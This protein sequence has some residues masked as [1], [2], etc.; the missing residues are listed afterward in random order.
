MSKPIRL[1]PEFIEECKKEFVETLG[2]MKISDGKISFSKILQTVNRK[3][4]VYFSEEAWFKMQALIKEFDKEVAWHGVAHRGED[5][6]KDEYFI[7][8]IVVYPQEVTGTTVEM[9][10]DKYAEWLCDN[11]EDERFNN[12]RM[13][14]HSHVNMGVSP[15]GVDLTHQEEILAQ[16]SDDMFYIFVIWNKNNANHMKI[17]DMK[18]NILFENGDIEYAVLSDGYGIAEFVKDAK[19]MVKEK[20][21]QAIGYQAPGYRY[22]NDGAGGY[23]YQ[24]SVTTKPA[25]GSA[26]AGSGVK[27][28]EKKTEDK[29]T[30]NKGKRRKGKRKKNKYTNPQ[31]S[32]VGD[33]D[34][35]NYPWD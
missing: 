20:S 22:Y 29:G 5:E 17:Y 18:K 32:L 13:Q 34:D 24:S 7:T 8:D 15:S 33:Y 11:F 19:S 35:D 21:Y 26:T 31:I 4:T 28:A 3:A 1:T 14:G 23:G 25:N 30:N 9:D 2:T 6:E 10:V 16:L 12:I 27:S